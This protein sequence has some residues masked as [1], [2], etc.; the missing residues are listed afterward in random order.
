MFQSCLQQI[1]IEHIELNCHRTYIYLGRVIYSFTYLFRRE[2]LKGVKRRTFF[3]DIPLIFRETTQAEL[4]GML[5]DLF[6][7][8]QKS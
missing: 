8:N 5:K 3:S 2:I 1:V 7:L 4:N 6:E